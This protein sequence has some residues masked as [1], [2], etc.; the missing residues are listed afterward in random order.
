MIQT[1][2]NVVLFLPCLLI[3]W[4]AINLVDYHLVRRGRYA[5]E[6]RFE[7]EGIYGRMNRWAIA[8][9]VLTC[10]LEVLFMNTSPYVGP[11]AND[12]GGAEIAWIVGLGLAATLYYGVAVS[13]RR[14]TDPRYARQLATAAP[15]VTQEPVQ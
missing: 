11:I 12:L 1:T 4:T 3:P 6:D 7:V 5:V 9:C 14:Q 13:L 2:N 15:A 10:G 8:I